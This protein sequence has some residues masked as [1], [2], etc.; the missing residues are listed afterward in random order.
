MIVYSISCLVFMCLDGSAY[1]DSFLFGLC[2]VQSLYWIDLIGRSVPNN[3][4]GRFLL[5]G[6]ESMYMFICFILHC[7]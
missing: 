4:F 3:P 5:D 2:L 7:I 1:T 6:V